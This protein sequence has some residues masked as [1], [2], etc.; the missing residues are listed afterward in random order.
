M[1]FSIEFVFGFEY[2]TFARDSTHNAIST[3]WSFYT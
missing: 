1:G 3:Y 2:T